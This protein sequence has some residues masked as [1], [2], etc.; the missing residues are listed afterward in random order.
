ME[1]E[2]SVVM[3]EF[4]AA[5]ATSS[6]KAARDISFDDEFDEIFGDAPA[7]PVGT[8]STGDE[9]ANASSE[10][11]AQLDK[12]DEE[13]DEIFGDAEQRQTETTENTD[14]DAPKKDPSAVSDGDQSVSGVEVR[15][16]TPASDFSFR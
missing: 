15:I 12:Y 1:F 13:F 8:A 4:E 7:N 2:D 11:A 5:A 16:G 3:A 6:E 9:N 10:V 14:K